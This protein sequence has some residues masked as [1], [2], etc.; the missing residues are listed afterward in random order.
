MTTNTRGVVLTLRYQ[1]A[2][3]LHLLGTSRSYPAQVT[4][5]GEVVVF[6]VVLALSVLRVTGI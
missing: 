6:C 4:V 5:A 1:V 2:A 3:V